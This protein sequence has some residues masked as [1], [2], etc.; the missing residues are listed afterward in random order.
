MLVVIGDS[1]GALTDGLLVP[2]DLES[3]CVVFKAVVGFDEGDLTGADVGFAVPF[4]FGWLVNEDGSPLDDDAV[5]R[6][7]GKELFCSIDIVVDD[8]ALVASSL[9]VVGIMVGE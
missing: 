8:G 7:V 6:V 1:E 9:A 5:G 3:G 4:E 2:G